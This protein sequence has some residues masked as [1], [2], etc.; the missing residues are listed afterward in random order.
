M[1]SKVAINK[2]LQ[3]CSKLDDG[4]ATSELGKG[5]T[6]KM[7]T[8]VTKWKRREETDRVCVNMQDRMDLAAT[9]RKYYGCFLDKTAY[10]KSKERFKDE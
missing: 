1:A 6:T 4:P 5:E 10:M 7:V 9:T 8:I 3:A 2:G